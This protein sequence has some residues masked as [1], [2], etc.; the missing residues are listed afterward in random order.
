MVREVDE[1]GISV[2]ISPCLYFFSGRSLILTRYLPSLAAYFTQATVDRLQT[3]DD[4][5]EL[6]S[7][8]VPQGKYISTRLGKPR[9]MDDGSGSPAVHD[10]FRPANMSAARTYAPFPLP[11]AVTPPHHLHQDSNSIQAQSHVIHPCGFDYTH[12]RPDQPEPPRHF[13][14]STPAHHPRFPNSPLTLPPI[15]AL[16]SNN[17]SQVTDNR[18]TWS[19]S[20]DN[21]ANGDGVSHHSGHLY[22]SYNQPGADQHSPM[23]RPTYYPPTPTSSSSQNESPLYPSP[24]S[25]LPPSEHAHQ[26]PTQFPLREA[27][28]SPYPS[29]PT[30]YPPMPPAQSYP[31]THSCHFS[32]YHINANQGTP[33]NTMAGHSPTMF[34][35]PNHTAETQ[36]P[37]TQYDSFDREFTP[38]QVPQV[39]QYYTTE[40]VPTSAPSPLH[41]HP[42]STISPR[43]P[44]VTLSVPQDH[45]P[46]PPMSEVHDDG[47]ASPQLSP[48]STGSASNKRLLDLAPL[49]SLQRTHPYRR[50]KFDDRALS[51][52]NSHR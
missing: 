26:L 43:R 46:S 13:Y 23:Q 51:L 42:G 37:Q 14:G 36:P 22:A 12:P 11:Y 28:P 6:A 25:G 33:P 4:M 34:T 48:R 29:P 20:H 15:H 2:R 5:P 38:S 1:N 10:V 45:R 39:S 17:G 7:L 24:V 21:S 50:D 30:R 35:S 31:D 18:Q 47:T 52:L 49:R 44:T 41:Q 8:E 27:Y 32:G 3:V 40:N 16:D 19:A 9:R